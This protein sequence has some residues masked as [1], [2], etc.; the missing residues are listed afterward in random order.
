M[1]L[2]FKVSDFRKTFNAVRGR[3][4]QKRGNVL[5]YI[6]MLMVIFAVLG[7]AMVSLFST[8]IGSSATVNDSRRASYLSEAGIRYT[9][10]ELR[11]ADFSKTAITTLNNT[12]YSVGEAS[13]FD[14]NVFSP[15][16]E[17]ASSYPIGTQSVN[18]DVPEGEVPAGYLASL[19][20]GDP[21]LLLVNY[22]YFN[23]SNPDAQSPI[24]G[25]T[26][27]TP[28][29]F[30]IQLSDDIVAHVNEQVALAVTPF[31]GGQTLPSP[32]VGVLDLKLTAKNVFS[33]AGGAFTVKDRDFYY[34]GIDTSFTDRV[35]LMGV[36]PA[37]GKSFPDDTTIAAA[38]PVILT[39]LRNRLIVS[40]GRS[41]QVSFGN[42]ID[43][44]A[45]IVDHSPIPASRKPDI[46]FD[47]EADLPGVLSQVEQNIN[48][49]NVYND[50][51]NKYLSLSTSGGSFGASWFKD[52]RSIGGVKSFCQSGGCLFNIGFR[53]FFILTFSGSTNGDGLTFSVLNGSNNDADSV[54]GDE[55]LSELLAYAGD[56]RQPSVPAK[57]YLDGEGQGLLA[58]KM[59]LEFDGKRN[60]QSQ[61]ICLDE[62]TVNQGSR[63]DPDFS[64]SDDT[65]QYVFWGRDD[66]LSGAQCRINP[67]TGTNKTY[68]DNRHDSVNAIW[69]YDSGSRI[70]SSPAIDNTDPIRIYTGL[71]SEDT[72]PNGDGGRLIRLNPSDGT[73]D[74]PGWERNPDTTPSNDDDINSA[75]ALDNSGNIYIG[76]DNNLLSKYPPSG[77]T[78]DRI[79]LDGDIEGKPA[80]SVDAGKPLIAQD[81][82]YVVTDNGSLFALTKNLA[83]KWKDAFNNPVPLD[84]GPAGSTYTSW[85][86]IRYD[87]G[88]GKNIV[89]VGS[90]NGRLYA[91]RDDGSSGASLNANFPYPTAGAIRG[92]P[93]INPVSGDVY[94]GSDDDQIRAIT[95]GGSFQWSATPDPQAPIVS[96]PAV[97]ADRGRVYVGSTNG[98]LY[99]L[100][101]LNGSVIWKYPD[102]VR[103]PGDPS[104]IGKVRG[105]P[106]IGSDG[107]IYFGSDVD[108]IGL[109]HG[110]LYA[111]NPNGTLRFKYPAAGSPIGA[112]RSKPA[113]GPDGIIY[114][115]ANDGKFY[116]ISSAANDPPN[117]QNLYLTSAELGAS[118]S[119]VNNWFAEGPWAVRVEVQRENIDSNGDGKF[120]YILKTW[121][122]KCQDANCLQ[123][124]NGLQLVGGFFQNTRFEYDWTTAGITPMTQ[125]IELS[126]TPDSFHD[127]FD[128]FLFGF[129]SAS[130]AS[131]TID[132][133]KF[134]LSFIRPNDPVQSD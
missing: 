48:V 28:T 56:S 129:T 121:L 123:D 27:G 11:A 51:G 92:T 113:I 111:L 14:L 124:A 20:V 100:D 91:V 119:D 127:R 31:A 36:S 15:W 50:P 72:L 71:S 46:E 8:S 75:P 41:G 53:A 116:A 103:T 7:V 112:V 66:L 74:P 35:R 114:F 104:D 76:N 52:T 70:L 22:N 23:L 69:I 107:A 17:S 108:D 32:G 73:T 54:G 97:D 3:L 89:Y 98:H 29:S 10:S 42:N 62:T 68:D 21:D 39:P 9:A 83:P 55:D 128:R 77:G 106:V 130:T 86:V 85:P 18:V 82:V 47:E 131:Q 30:Q 105:D 5:V 33:Q 93:A 134:Q 44:A 12:V 38:D 6:V 49:V 118:V 133:Q 64:G 132:I 19:P 99:A 58:P 126:N 57:P 96:S 102:L 40:E 80:V 95:S 37:A 120:T 25:F 125:V 59:A 4:S 110:Y 67:L 84:I 65:V 2:R 90:L 122:K 79:L 63:F 78:P 81:T 13:R 45:A 109:G 60:N 87:S 117:I 94:F 61:T 115:G 88:L 101:T 24:T 16:F 43:Y 1:T 34:K 26:A